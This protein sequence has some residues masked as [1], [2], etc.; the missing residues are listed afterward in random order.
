MTDQENIA[1]IIDRMATMV[2][3]MEAMQGQILWIMKRLEA[4]NF[5]QKEEK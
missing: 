2:K 3:Q 1:W 4:D 5:E